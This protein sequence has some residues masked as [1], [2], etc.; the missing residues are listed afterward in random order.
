VREV[1]V[2]RNALFDKLLSA[3]RPE[4]FSAPKIMIR[5]LNDWELLKT[6]FLAMRRAKAQLRNGEFTSVWQKPADGQDHYMHA[7]G[8]LWVASQ[9]RGIA[10]G[11]TNLGIG[12]SKFKVIDP[13]APKRR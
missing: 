3:I 1:S 12:V 4:E 5:R 10:A 8:Y 2:N 13:T 11:Y 6:H 7:M 9:M